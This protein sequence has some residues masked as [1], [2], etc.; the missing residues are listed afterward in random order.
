VLA[1]WPVLTAPNAAPPVALLAG[2][3][4]L[5]VVFALVALD[6]MAAA[7]IDQV[8]WRVLARDRV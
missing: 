3:I 2:A 4:A 1:A 7:S 6:R 5:A 8:S